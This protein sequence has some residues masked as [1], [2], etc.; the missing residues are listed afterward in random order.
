MGIVKQS[1]LDALEAMPLSQVIEKFVPDLK[2]VGADFRGTSPFSP[3]ENKTSFSV[4]DSTGQWACFKTV[5]SGAGPFSFLLDLRYDGDRKRFQ[6]AVRELCDAVGILF[7]VDEK[8]VPEEQRKRRADREHYL[9]LNERAQALFSKTL[10]Q[11]E[12]DLVGEARAY[13][14]SRGIDE[15][16]ALALGF[17]FTPGGGYLGAKIPAED[18]AAAQA[19]GLLTE[20]GDYFWQPRITFPIHDAKGRVV[21]FAGRL[22]G[23]VKKGDIK[24]LNTKNGPL[25]QKGELLFGLYQSRR[26]ARE[27]QRIYVVE[28]YFDAIRLHLCGLPAVALCGTA[29][30]EKQIELLK[31]N[32][33]RTVAFLDNDDAGT[34][35]TIRSIQKLMKAGLD[36]DVLV[37]REGK[38][39]DDWVSGLVKDGMAVADTLLREARH[40]SLWFA[41]HL[42]DQHNESA[43]SGY[44][45]LDRIVGE[46]CSLLVGILDRNAQVTA[47]LKDLAKLTGIDLK[48]WRKEIDRLSKPTAENLAEE[49]SDDPEAVNDLIEYNFFERDGCIW[50]RTDRGRR[51]I[52]NFTMRILQHISTGSDS[53]LRQV[54]I[55]N[56]YGKQL[57]VLMSSDD[58]VSREAFRKSLAS[59]G[60]FLFSGSAADLDAVLDKY[61]QEMTEAKEVSAYGWQPTEQV[62]AYANG[63][64]DLREGG[65][66]Q[67]IP[68]SEQ[69]I[70]MIGDHS[71]FLPTC[72]TIFAN[73][74]ADYKTQKKLLYTVREDLRMEDWTSRIQKVYRQNALV[75]LGFAYCALN[76]DIVRA[77]LAGKHPLLNFYGEPGGGKNTMVDAVL[78]LLGQ[79]QDQVVLESTSTPVGIGRL[80][81]QF[82]NI[83]ITLDEFKNGIR[84]DMI[85]MLKQIYDDGTAVKGRKDGTNRT[86]S[87]PILCEIILLGQQMPVMEMGLFKRLI[88]VE[89][90]PDKDY[91]KA[92]IEH[93]DALK[94]LEAKPGRLSH[95]GAQMLLTRRLFE[96]HFPRFLRENKDFLRKGRGQLVEERLVNNYAAVLAALNCFALFFPQC[97][98]GLDKMMDFLKENM[99][100]QHIL[101]ETHDERNKFWDTMEALCTQPN[102]IREGI[103]YEFRNGL[104]H[105]PIQVVHPYYVKFR[106]EQNDPDILDRGS[107]ESYL[108]SQAYYK[109]TVEKIS[110]RFRGG[111]RGRCMT[112]DWSDESNRPCNLLIEN[113]FDPQGGLAKGGG[114]EAEPNNNI[115]SATQGKLGFNPQTGDTDN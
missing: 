26:A 71:M 40:C 65:T 76:R 31:A 46:V 50:I 34:E 70:V 72:S 106:R 95:L 100:G 89:V 94:V 111:W 23:E 51:R 69:G 99:L 91:K 54:M 84:S 48:V 97:D 28:G 8:E 102:G 52:S 108:R 49:L 5:K 30:S 60:N 55:R 96:T 44:A 12:G 32:T 103:H 59:H 25:Y 113:E 68:A 114:T 14:R 104:L 42:K 73:H 101:I 35:A 79:S 86:N 38:D 9:N 17:G 80:L 27:S 90:K 85:A 36:T 15:E 74:E 6:E 16:A 105:L 1:V 93:F 67:F 43:D 33:R 53:A 58:M 92:N 75:T 115:P 41:S 10:A 61:Q 81:S 24:Y 22:L 87:V 66:G 29:L 20:K 112:F 107:L 2:K 19:C 88:C 57:I 4:K 39:A 83:P 11:S 78:A 64:L 21:G 18:R 56:Q 63:I 82:R 109:G 45:D 47:L 37:P 62:F 3:G 7:E 13:L 98:L 77:H 110:S